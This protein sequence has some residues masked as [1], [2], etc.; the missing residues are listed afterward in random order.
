MKTRGLKK[1]DILIQVNQ[2]L[3]TGKMDHQIKDPTNTCD[4]LTGNWA[5]NLINLKH[6][7]TII[8]S[9]DMDI[10]IKNS[11]YAYNSN[12][13]LN[14]VKR[15]INLLIRTLNSNVLMFSPSYSIEV[16]KK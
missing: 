11:E 2:F 6:L 12:K 13:N 8:N 5:E 15:I 16:E 14:Y 9:Y 7:K 10:Q 3:K 4:P 1:K